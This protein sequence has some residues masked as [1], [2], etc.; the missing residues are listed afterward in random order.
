M[1]DE[2]LTRTFAQGR[3]ADLAGDMVAAEHAYRQVLAEDFEHAGALRHLGMIAFRCGHGDAALEL[4]RRSVSADPGDAGSLG[5]LAAICLDLGHVSE[6]EVFAREGVSL[7]P[8]HVPARACLAEALRR[9]ARWDEALEQARAVLAAAPDDIRALDVLAHGHFAR[10]DYAQA[11]AALDVWER[12]DPDAAGALYLRGV[13]RLRQGEPREAVGSLLRALQLRP[14]DVPTAAALASALTSCGQPEAAEAALRLIENQNPDNS[15]IC[16]LL[17]AALSAQGKHDEAID[18]GLRALALDP[19]QPSAHNNLATVYHTRWKLAEAERHFRK[20]VDLDPASG[21]K[22]GNLAALLWDRG[23]RRES[24]ALYRRAAEL[25]PDNPATR[26]NLAIGLMNAGE[27]GAAWVHYE[28]GIRQGQRRPPFALDVPFLGVDEEPE[29]KTILVRREQGVGD[30]V[31]FASV[32]PDLIGRAGHC[33]V[34]CKA[35]LVPLLARSFPKATVLAEEETRIMGSAIAADRQVMLGSLPLRYRSGLDCFPGPRRYLVPDPERT[36]AFRRRLGGLPG[37]IKAAVL[38]RGRDRDEAR[39]EG[40]NYLT[41]EQFFPLLA[42]PEVAAVS[43]QYDA[44]PDLVRR[45]IEEARGSLGMAPHLFED[46]DCFDDLDGVAALLD[47]CDVIIGPPTA[48]LHIAG[49]L[50]K[51]TLQ[52]SLAPMEYN[53]GQSVCPFTPSVHC[54]VPARFHDK[55]EVVRLLRERIPAFIAGQPG[56]RS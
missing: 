52:W 22:L 51:P 36:G 42:L 56:N 18:L 11:L 39:Q 10:R 30:A 8:S 50:G 1:M 28:F 29:G 2:D 20:A 15:E 13:I 16:S 26:F 6:A 31:L 54:V 47:A 32:L 27:V 4:V 24:L 53:L 41:P 43:V 25:D 38:W 48:T 46:L 40:S 23:E 17:C 37:R 3:E 45:E 35:K 12:L 21:V 5:D 55:D 44:D 7:D 19:D 14:D 33:F 49:G 34:E 9:M